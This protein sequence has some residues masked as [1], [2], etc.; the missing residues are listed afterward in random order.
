MFLTSCKS[1]I[2]KAE[3][4]IRAYMFET[5]YDYDSYQ[6]INTEKDGAFFKH[7][8]RCKTAGG[9]SRIHT[10]KFFLNIDEGRISSYYDDDGELQFP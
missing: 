4:I 7:K 9:L 6:P 10:W 5:L 1:E 2:E 8:F 3:E